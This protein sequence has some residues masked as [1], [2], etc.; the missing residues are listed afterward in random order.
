MNPDQT[1]P[2][3]KREQ[4]ERE[5]SDLGAYCLQYMLHVPENISSKAEEN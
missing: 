3:P 2:F 4:L 5:Q 1:A